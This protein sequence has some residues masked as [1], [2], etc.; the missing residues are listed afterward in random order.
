MS[1]KPDLYGPNGS[2]DS[3]KIGISIAG[4]TFMGFIVAGGIFF[5]AW[6]FVVVLAW[7]GSFLPPESKEAVDPTPDSF[8]SR[9][10]EEAIE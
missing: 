3:T 4:Q 10:V 7:L 5:G 1:D 2:G 6:I 8:V 9:T